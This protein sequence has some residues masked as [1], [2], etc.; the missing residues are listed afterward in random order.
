MRE[1]WGEPFT[2]ADF[3]RGL[4]AVCER[5]GVTTDEG[6]PSVRE[7]VMA[8]G[9]E[10]L[11]WHVAAMPRN[12][13]GCEQGQVCGRCGF[14]CPLGAKQ[15]TLV[16]W[17]VDAQAAGARILVETRALRVVTE[18]GAAD[19]VE[20]R[21]AAGHRV[22]VRARVVVA[23][24][25]ALQTPVLLRRSGLTNA[26]VGRHLHLHPTTGVSGVFDEEI[27]P[28]EGTMQALYSDEHRD[29]DGAGYGLKYETAPVHPGVL[30]AFAPWESAREHRELVAR[31][32]QLTGIGLLLRDRSEGEVR[33]GRNGGPRVRY[34]LG[35]EDVRHVRVGH[36][37]AARILEAAGARRIFSSHARLVSYEPGRG[38][39]DD[40]LRAADAVGFGP[41]RCAFY[42]F[43]QMGTARVGG[44]PATSACK[45]DG[46]TWETRGLY[47][48]DGSSFPSASGVNPM[49]TIEALAHLNASRL[50]ARLT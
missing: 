45:P 25:G 30:V 32:P 3:E 31:L 43:H 2:S 11:G 46:E 40:F 20:A 41:G 1:E 6:R 18:A 37:G 4:D 22:A 34:R 28:W 48:M 33:V 36:N 17:L 15:S 21:T 23:C 42:G 7:N 13:R 19:G 10:R 16:T 24:A 29:L 35:P 12:V 14:G 49:I 38:S 39:R 26:H 47:V 50:A 44:S 9:L 27:R 8:R 5:V